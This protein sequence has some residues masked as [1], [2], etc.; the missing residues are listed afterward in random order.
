MI[1]IRARSRAPATLFVVREGPRRKMDEVE[2]EE[3][4]EKQL[5]RDRDRA[6]V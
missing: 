3:E 1:V 6:V 5:E 4:E 2:E